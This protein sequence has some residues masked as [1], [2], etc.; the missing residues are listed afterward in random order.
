M[1]PS[2]VAATKASTVPLFSPVHSC[3]DP[4]VGH[5]DA[6]YIKGSKY[7]NDNFQMKQGHEYWHW[8]RLGRIVKI[9]VRSSLRSFV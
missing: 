5:V 7:K 2:F 1:S 6:G 4:S 9:R 8:N 3:A